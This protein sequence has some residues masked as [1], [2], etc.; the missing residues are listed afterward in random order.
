MTPDRDIPLATPLS[1]NS[2]LRALGRSGLSTSAYASLDSLHG[3]PA[4]VEAEAGATAGLG[5][6]ARHLYPG[7][8]VALTAAGAAE[9]LSEH[10]S[11]PVML[12]ALL[13]GMA[14][15]FLREEALFAPGIGFSAKSVLRLGIALLGIRITLY[16]LV[17]LGL[18]PIA[19]VLL[20][21]AS[22]LLFGLVLS[23]FMRLD[24]NFGLLSAGAVGICGA[25][26]ALAI[27]AILPR[28]QETERDTILAVIV[29]TTLSTLASSA[30]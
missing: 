6:R 12:L 4:E 7:I 8:L 13:I 2:A 27:S 29:V 22:T 18:F 10:Y 9:W 1:Q 16:Q 3:L 5:Q 30:S 20:S 19:L 26:A 15:N 17:G 21:I 14:F 11:T 24:R 23:R 28:R 25:S